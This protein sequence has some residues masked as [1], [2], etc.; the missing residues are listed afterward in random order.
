MKC[1]V[2]C[3]CLSVCGCAKSTCKRMVANDMSIWNA[4][5]MFLSEGIAPGLGS[6]GRSTA[7][8]SNADL[9]LSIIRYPVSARSIN[10]S[11]ASRVRFP[12]RVA[13]TDRR[14]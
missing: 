10:P 13:R 1:H 5:T 9:V 2:V 4:M 14:I 7:Q 12:S 3:T 8:M 6:V 11:I